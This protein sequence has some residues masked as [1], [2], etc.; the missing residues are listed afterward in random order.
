MRNPLARLFD[1]RKSQTIADLLSAY[2]RDTPTTSRLTDDAAMRVGTF[3]SCLR[4]VSGIE[5]S[6]PLHVM[7]RLPDGGKE[8]QVLNSLDQLLSLKP[9]AWQTPFEWREQMTAHLLLRGNA[10]SW[11]GWAK[12]VDRTAQTRNRATE[13]IPMH[14]D[15]VDVEATE[16][17]RP[18]R[19]FLKR[20]GGQRTELPADEVLHIRGLSTDGVKGRSVIS[21]ARETIGVALDTQR[22][23]AR[24]FSNDATPGVVL[25]HPSKLS[26]DAA[27]RLRESWDDAHAGNTR[28]TA[29]LEEGMTLERL[30][31]APEDAQFLQ[32][33]DM[34]QSQICG[35]FPVPP[36][37]VGIVDKSTSWGSGIEQQN[38][39]FLTYCIGII[40][41]RFESAIRRCVI[42]ADETFFVEHLVDGLQRSDIK[43]RYGAYA[44]GR[45]WGWL[46]VNDIRA[47]ENLNPIG[48]DGDVYLQ[49]L[50]MV[51]AGDVPLGDPP[52]TDPAA[53]RG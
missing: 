8:R 43:S 50:N 13:L 4:L 48:P 30:T 11:I 37:L 42:E 9:N 6:L 32:T 17:N 39:Q 47:R 16:W 5:A 53:N 23:A 44:V 2:I 34:Q 7:R 40:N 41:R 36:H 29:V 33:R 28:R 19:Y 10:Y 52:E 31:L 26:K 22:Y 35:L 27:S 15:L 46:S 51:P 45:Q 18:P 49:P 1:N 21:D 24:L 25:K 3:N 20:K 12:V 14:P 38:I